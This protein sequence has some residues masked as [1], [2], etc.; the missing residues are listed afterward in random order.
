MLLGEYTKD[1]NKVEM[2]VSYAKTNIFDGGA[3]FTETNYSVSLFGKKLGNVAINIKM[4]TSDGK[5]EMKLSLSTKESASPISLPDDFNV[6][7]EVLDIFD[8]IED[9]I[10]TDVNPQS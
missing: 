6:Y 2:N 7:E 3:M 9:I 10:P 5:G 8:N 1:G 4:G